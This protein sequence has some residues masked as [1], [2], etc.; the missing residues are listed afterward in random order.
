MPTL[1]SVVGTKSHDMYEWLMGGA[2]I[3]GK[4]APTNRSKHNMWLV[5]ISWPEHPVGVFLG[6]MYVNHM[7]CFIF[8]DHFSMTCWYMF[9]F[10]LVSRG[11]C[12]CQC[13]LVVVILYQYVLLPFCAQASRCLN[14]GGNTRVKTL[15]WPSIAPV[16]KTGIDQ[17]FEKV[18][19]NQCGATRLRHCLLPQLLLLMTHCQEHWPTDV[20][21]LVVQLSLVMQEYLQQA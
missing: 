11:F 14:N 6:V 8:H 13:G 15:N 4:R 20:I 10:I 16:L 17:L 3:P 5:Y 21:S 12:V 19:S 2:R 7:L 18:W 9:C 1:F